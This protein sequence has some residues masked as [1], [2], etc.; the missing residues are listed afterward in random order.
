MGRGRYCV[1]QKRDECDSQGLP[2]VWAMIALTEMAGGERSMPGGHSVL[3]GHAS[4]VLVGR[5]S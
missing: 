2:R 5:H 1:G 3:Q 4:E